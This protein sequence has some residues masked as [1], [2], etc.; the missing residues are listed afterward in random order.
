[1]RSTILLFGQSKTTLLRSNALERNPRY[2][3]IFIPVKIY[4]HGVY[5]F[6][7]ARRGAFCGQ[8]NLNG[9]TRLER[10]LKNL[11]A[12]SV[13]FNRN[14][15]SPVANA[16]S[17]ATPQLEAQPYYITAS[18]Y[19]VQKVES[20]SVSFKRNILNSVVAAK[21]RWTLD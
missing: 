20:S 9:R 12:V 15:D 7:T 1:M 16:P 3:G 17:P 10:P 2:R 21:Q 5:F 8:K 18:F 19:S 14:K 13:D 4:A 11:D 6:S